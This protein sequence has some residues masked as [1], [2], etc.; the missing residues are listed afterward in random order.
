MGDSPNAFPPMQDIMMEA[1]AVHHTQLA[2]DISS[3]WLSTNA[4]FQSVSGQLA[5][6]YNAFHMGEPG[7]GGEYTVQKGFGWSNGVLLRVMLDYSQDNYEA[8]LSNW[9][10]VVSG[11]AF[12]VVALVY[13]YLGREDVPKEGNDEGADALISLVQE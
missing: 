3:H 2:F 1:L 10:Y 12:A 8:A 5:E 9:V 7:Q 11:I 4:I 6:K 13:C